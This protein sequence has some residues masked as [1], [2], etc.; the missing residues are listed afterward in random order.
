MIYCFF[1]YLILFQEAS[2]MM[3]H[4]ALLF[5]LMSGSLCRDVRES[6]SI[7]GYEACV[8]LGVEKLQ[9]DIAQCSKFIHS[10]K[11]STSIQV[12]SK[13]H[14]FTTWVWQVVK[15]F[16]WPQKF[17]PSVIF[18]FY[19]SSVFWCKGG[20]ILVWRFKIRKEYC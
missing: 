15:Y 5:T 13:Y 3:I 17:V 11:Y 19:C 7:L 16:I 12:S 8:N 9:R 2:K 18:V 6:Q 1:T 10:S 4:F 20:F 14:S